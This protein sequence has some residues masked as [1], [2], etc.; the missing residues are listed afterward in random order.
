MY[1]IHRLTSSPSMK[2]QKTQKKRNKNCMLID[3]QFPLCCAAC[4][5]FAMKSKRMKNTFFFRQQNDWKKKWKELKTKT[6][7]PTPIKLNK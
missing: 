6:K 5:H 7:E 1:D 3:L 2:Q 4:N